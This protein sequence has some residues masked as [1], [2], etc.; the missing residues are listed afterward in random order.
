V[1]DYT[2]EDFADTGERYDLVLDNVASRPLSDFRAVLKPKGKYVLVGGGGP[3]D[4]G[5]IGPLIRPMKAWV[6]AK[7]VSQEMGM[8][9]ADLNKPDLT[10]LAELAEQG[11]VNPVIDRKYP[12]NDVRSAVK[13]VEEGHARGKVVIAF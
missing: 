7:F 11:K 13:Y 12:L 10:T 3:N 9:F 1:V 4:Q 6:L 8:V 2:K 5:L